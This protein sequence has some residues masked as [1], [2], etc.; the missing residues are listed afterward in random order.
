VPGVA[1]DPVVTS[2][3]MPGETGE[4]VATARKCIDTLDR[5]SINCMRCLS[6]NITLKK[7]TMRYPIR[8]VPTAVG[9]VRAT[10]RD[11]NRTVPPS[12]EYKVMIHYSLVILS[13]F[14]LVLTANT[15]CSPRYQPSRAGVSKL[16]PKEKKERRRKRLAAARKAIAAEDHRQAQLLLRKR[17]LKQ[18]QRIK[19]AQ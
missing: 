13:R 10:K 12:G 1:G 3:P 9:T 15:L 5:V 18:H 11:S 16:T 8:A 14:V 17:K 2:D 7:C 6:L 19:Q 4:P